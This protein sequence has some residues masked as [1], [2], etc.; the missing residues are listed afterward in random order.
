MSIN[1]ISFVWLE[2]TKLRYRTI[3]IGLFAI[4]LSY[5]YTLL[6]L[7]KDIDSISSSL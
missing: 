3:V 5:S 7:T 6:D 1:I 4:C 2:R